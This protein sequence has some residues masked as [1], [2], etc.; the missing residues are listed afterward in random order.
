MAENEYL[1]SSKS[2][3]WLSV[4]DGLCEK[5]D[6]DVLFRSTQDCFYKSL[7]E[8]GKNTP[9]PELLAN[10]DNREK[11]GELCRSF[12]GAG[13]VKALLLD[14]AH[15]NSDRA[16]MLKHF[17]RSGLGNCLYDIPALAAERSNDI[18]LSDSRRRLEEVR[19]RLEP[20]IR[21]IADKW[22]VDP[23]WKPQKPRSSSFEA[24]SAVDQT[25]RLLNHS[26][27]V[28]FRKVSK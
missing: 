13:D 24:A 2:R 4:A 14:A 17:L 12:P 23:S 9:F 5:V 15:D 20:D 26:L 19:I 21:R 10:V 8:I 16:D 1:D 7:R 25:Q 3:R 6:N 18:S 27:L 11:L 22:A 28:D